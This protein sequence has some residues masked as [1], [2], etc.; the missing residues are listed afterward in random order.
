[1]KKK[2]N[3]FLTNIL[4]YLVKNEQ[5]DLPMKWFRFLKW[6]LLPFSLFMIFTYDPDLYMIIILICY[7]IITYVSMLF[8]STASKKYNNE[9][10]WNLGICFILPPVTLF[11]VTYA[12]W[13]IV[14]TNNLFIF[15]AI[16]TV[17]LSGFV[18]FNMKS[19]LESSVL[20]STNT[21]KED[22]ISILIVIVLTMICYSY[23][24]I[25]TTNC[26][27]DY[28]EAKIMKTKIM[29]KIIATDLYA[30]DYYFLLDSENLFKNE[31]EIAVKKSFFMKR[32]KG[33]IVELKIKQGFL[34]IPWYK[35]METTHI[36]GEIVDREE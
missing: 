23:G 27:L 8:Y 15:T 10:I 26:S 9:T 31:L 7:P 3:E 34:H 28:S 6:T 24:V 20:Y 4:A 22:M 1:M 16:A 36:N 2:R 5:F 13:N 18:C 35:I 32:K 33:D 19:Q 12:K 25:I 14:Y 17:L 21:V 29:K 30:T 11:C